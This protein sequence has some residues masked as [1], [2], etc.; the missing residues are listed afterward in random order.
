MRFDV[1]GRSVT[2]SPWPV[3]LHRDD[4]QIVTVV[5]ADHPAGAVQTI[6]L[7]GTADD[8]PWLTLV[9]SGRLDWE[10]AP[11]FRMEPNAG[12]GVVIR[13][14][15]FRKAATIR[16]PPVDFREGGRCW[17]FVLLSLSIPRFTPGAADEGEA[18]VGWYPRNDV[19]C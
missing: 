12:D 17:Q 19:Q 13:G 11:G 3:T 6:E 18:R 5:S 2:V 4:R 10:L 14:P 16:E 15:D 9:S 7:R 8:T 1:D